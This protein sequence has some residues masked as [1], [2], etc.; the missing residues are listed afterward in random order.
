MDITVITELCVAN[1]GDH[2]RHDHDVLPASSCASLFR[3]F[4]LFQ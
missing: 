1:D 2:V 3:E 4:Y